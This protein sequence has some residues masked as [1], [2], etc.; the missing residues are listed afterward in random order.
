MDIPS[1]NL[2]V[3][4]GLESPFLDDL[5]IL[6][7]KSSWITA[8]RRPWVLEVLGG[9][10]WFWGGLITFLAARL[11]R[12]SLGLAATLSTLLLHRTL[13]HAINFFL[14]LARHSWFLHCCFLGG[15]LG[16]VLGRADNVLGCPPYKIFSWTCCYASKRNSP[17]KMSQGVHSMI[18]QWMWRQTILPCS[19]KELMS[20]LVD[21]LKKYHDFQWRL[22]P[23]KQIVWLHCKMTKKHIFP[24]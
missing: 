13:A 4:S 7:S 19:P 22:H 24:I 2:A 17:H 21:L 9:F 15:D 6:P 14:S 5:P 12:Y 8:Y 20:C 10:G 11:T 18:Q 16:G 3:R 1:G 23:L